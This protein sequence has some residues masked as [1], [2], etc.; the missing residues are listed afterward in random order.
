MGKFIQEL[1]MKKVASERS[2]EGWSNYNWEKRK[3]RWRGQVWCG[4]E[5]PSRWENKPWSEKT[6]K[7]HLG[8]TFYRLLKVNSFPHTIILLEGTLN[9]IFR[10]GAWG[11]SSE[12]LQAKSH[13]WWVAQVW[14]LPVSVFSFQEPVTSHPPPLKTGGIPGRKEG[15]ANGAFLPQVKRLSVVASERF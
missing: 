5:M 2:L 12:V 13:H 1:F 7:C 4:E 11:T 9:L 6:H 15:Q 10:R 3:G 8:N 14:Q